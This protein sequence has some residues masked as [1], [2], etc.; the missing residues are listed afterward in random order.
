M[1][2]PLLRTLLGVAVGVLSACGFRGSAYLP[3][4]A[5]ATW[6][7]RVVQIQADGEHLSK[8][9]ETSLGSVPCEQGDCFAI[10][11]GTGLTHVIHRAGQRGLQRIA[12]A[13]T[14]GNVVPLAVPEWLVPEVDNM[15]WQVPTQTVL[16]SRRNDDYEEARFSMQLSAT[17]DYRVAEADVSVSV[18]AGSFTACMRMEG[19]ARMD[20]P[21]NRLGQTSHISI[22][23]QDWYCPGVGLVLRE[24]VESTDND[25]VA[26]GRYRLELEALKLP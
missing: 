13:E 2:Q 23:Q 8:L 4:T 11:T 16:L 22:R 20:V 25:F 9:Q 3:S 15:T 14:P 17:L 18:P 26:D 10:A 12:R 1:G 6:Q 5:G 7:Y 24:R 19:T 21:R